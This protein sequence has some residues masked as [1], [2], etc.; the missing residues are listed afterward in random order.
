M[1]LFQFYHWVSVLFAFGFSKT[2]SKT[3]SLR[4]MLFIYAKCGFLCCFLLN[5]GLFFLHKTSRE[6]GNHWAYRSWEDYTDAAITK[7][8]LLPINLFASVCVI[9]FSPSF[10]LGYLVFSLGD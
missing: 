5:I 9:F 2:K 8:W 4:R 3:L 1:A 6:C 10:Y 7:V